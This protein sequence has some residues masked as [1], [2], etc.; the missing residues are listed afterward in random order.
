MSDELQYYG[1]PEDTGLTVTAKVYNNSGAQVGTDVSCTEV[2]V[3]AIYQGDMPTASSGIYVVR[4]TD[5]ED[6]LLGHGK[7]HWDGTVEIDESTVSADIAALNNPSSSDNA[8]AV[9]DALSSSHTISG[10]FGEYLDVAV[11]SRLAT[12]GYTAPDNATIGSNGFAL[13]NIEI[14]VS[15]INAAMLTIDGIVDDILEDTQ[16]T[17]PGQISS[18][19]NLSAGAVWDEAISGHVTSGSTGEKLNASLTKN[20]YLGTK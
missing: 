10:S 4:F 1:A 15:T 16:T 8:S 7:I 18:L 13:G 19:N 2:G 20:F 12:S 3:L 17:I 9:W 5:S 6:S 11:S 14:E